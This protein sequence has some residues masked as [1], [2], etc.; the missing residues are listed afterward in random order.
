MNKYFPKNFLW[1][2]AVAANQLEGAYNV[3]GKGLSTSD[4]SPRGIAFPPVYPVDK[5]LHYPSHMGID[6]Y[7]KYKEDI[8][9]FKEM[10]FKCFRTSIAWTRIFPQGDEAT[11]NEEGLKF[12]DN[13]FDE[14]IKNNIIPLVTLSHY[15]MPMGLVEKYGGW[16]NRKVVGFFENYARTVFN[17]Y[18]DKVRYWM[19]FN[20]INFINHVPFT[21]GGIVIREGENAAAVKMQGAHH[22]FVASALAVKLAK[23]IIKDVKIGCM[24]NYTPSY[25]YTSAPEDVLASIN[26]ERDV[27]MY[28]DVQVRGYYPSYAKAFLAQHYIDIK[29]EDGD[30]EI[31]KNTVDFIGFSYYSSRCASADE[32]VGKNKDLIGGGVKNPLLKESQWGWTIDA[33]GLRIALNNLYDRYQKPLFIVENGLGARDVLE[34]GKVHDDYRIDYLKS[35]L[36]QVAKAINEDGVDLMGYTSWGCIDLVSASTAQMSKRYGYIYVD[37]DDEGKGSMK[38]IPKDSFYWY[39]KVIKTNGDSVFD[40]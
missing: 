5:N 13:L 38:R 1:G 12:Y 27:L 7:H 28:A 11:P 21:G 30:E 34:D 39:Q 23:E 31:L 26:M 29:M 9:L 37:L 20:E 3:G 17:R 16:R 19:T 14:L 18:K 10:G 4:V 6:F 24:I 33:V 22:Q 32:S 15:E 35:H 2:G 36:Q 8:A 40:D 25:A